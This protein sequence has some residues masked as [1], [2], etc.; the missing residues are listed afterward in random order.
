MPPNDDP[1][2]LA[3]RA[4]GLRRLAMTL[5]ESTA[6]RLPALAGDDTWFGPTAEHFRADASALLRAVNDAV[7]MLWRAAR[8]LETRAG[9]P[10]A[11]TRRLA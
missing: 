11:T 2:E 7:T 8:D 6:H 3:R 5:D 4:A 9:V 10:A 1:A